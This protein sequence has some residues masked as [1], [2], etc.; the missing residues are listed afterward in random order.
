MIETKLI[1]IILPI[2]NGEKYL[3]EAI[4]SCLKQ[5]YQNFE[6]IIVND[7]SI[8]S[9]LRI[10]KYYENIDK[11]IK[12][13]SNDLNRNLPA[14]LNIGHRAANGL[15]LTWSSDDNIL[16][17][18]MLETLFNL[19][20]GTES[21]LVFSNYDVIEGNGDY[22]RTH[23]FGPVCSLPF[24]SCIGASFLYKRKVFEE[25]KGYDE[26]LH[27]VED[28]DFWIRAATNYRFYHT[29]KSLYEYRVHGGNLT[30]EIKKKL[31]F[32]KSFQ[33]KHMQVYE[34]LSNSL[35]WSK[36]TKHFLAMVR[37]FELW[38]WNFFEC[39]YQ[40]IITDLKTFQASINANDKRSVLQMMDLMLRH[41][42]LNTN[43]SK[44]HIKWLF[45]KRPTIFFDFY[46]SK[47]TSFM[48]IKKLV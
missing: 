12:I 22:R 11:R 47:K 43:P 26:D 40:V 33:I 46:Y 45:L 8:D 42:I 30:S 23:K 13:I 32:K 48:I 44:H 14:S 34:K 41:K 25:L 27:T 7:C 17:K 29:N 39:N 6:L 37:G 9:S 15:F 3:A 20:N 10:A 35:G 38:N 18:E 31:A 1:S 36:C 16:K 4:E 2:Y 28:Y 24:G 19:I 5:T 21:D